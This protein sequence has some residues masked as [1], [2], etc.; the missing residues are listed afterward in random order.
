MKISS[1][2]GKLLCLLPTLCLFGFAGCAAVSNPVLDGIPVRRVPPEF[3][4]E[5]KEEEIKIPLTLLRQKPPKIYRLGPGDILG[6]FIEGVVGEKGVQPPVRIN[7]AEEGRTQPGLGFPIPVRED[8]TLLLPFIDPVKVTG[9]SVKEVTD[10]LI[11]EY[12]EQ[13]KILQKDRA[14]IS[15]T[16]LEPRKTQVLVIR[17]DS[18]SLTV[19]AGGVIGNASRGTGAVLFLPAYENDLLNVLTR[20]G[21]LPGLDAA[22]EI[23]IQRGYYRE[24]DNPDELL[25][26]L[27][28]CQSGDKGVGVMDRELAKGVEIVR[29]PLRLRPGE[30]LPFR[31]KDIILETGDVVFIDTRDTE[32]FYTGGQLIPRQFV[33][34]RDFDLRVVDAIALANGPLVNG[35]ISQNNLSGQIVQ[36]GLGAASPSAVTVL[37]KVKGRGQIRIR[38]DLNRALNDPRE[39]IIIKAGDVLIMQESIGES[40]SR[41]LTGVIQF[42]FF[43]RLLDRPDATLSNTISGP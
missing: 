24:G 12:T 7:V 22:D 23:V 6:I 15:V 14:V 30:P 3:L 17:Q 36:T 33:I 9:L 13:K 18:G 5:P 35:L 28:Q 29:V 38:V 43:G 27:Q 20:T 31:P 16:L 37:R 11:K 26:W 21:G 2:L 25:R 1:W 39:N 42:N 4:A 8:G 10:R 32:V 19:G 40:V 41:Y 34:P